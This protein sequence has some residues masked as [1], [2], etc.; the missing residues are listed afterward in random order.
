MSRVAKLTEWSSDG[1]QFIDY[2]R[3]GFAVILQQSNAKVILKKLDRLSV[4]N[5]EEREEDEE[6][7]SEDRILHFVIHYSICLVYRV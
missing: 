5:N 7:C 2:W 4:G 6:E 3:K 1:K